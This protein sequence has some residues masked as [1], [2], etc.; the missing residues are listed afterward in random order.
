MVNENERLDVFWI[1]DKKVLAMLVGS[2]HPEIPPRYYGKV[3]AS[4]AGS[5]AL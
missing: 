4:M 5:L 2:I 1:T 3:S